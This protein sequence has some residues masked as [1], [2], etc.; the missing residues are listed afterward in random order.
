MRKLLA[1]LVCVLF[2]HI[3][4][5]RLYRYETDG[6]PQSPITRSRPRMRAVGFECSWCGA[7]RLYQ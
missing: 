3:E 4:G 5:D 2:G 1:S 7:R 6:D